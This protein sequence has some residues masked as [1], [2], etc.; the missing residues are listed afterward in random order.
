MRSIELVSALA[1]VA[2]M[3]GSTGVAAVDLPVPLRSALVV[4]DDRGQCPAA[5]FT[6]I[7]AAVDVATPGSVV[8]VCPGRYEESV[9]VGTSLRLVGVPGVYDT[10][11]CFAASLQALSPLDYPIVGPADDPLDRT[12]TAFALAADDVDLSGFVVVGV[13]RGV[14]T[15]DAYS[16]YRIHHNLFANNTLG[17]HLGSGAGQA[18][19]GPSRVD[20]NCLRQN[21][22]GFS[23]DDFE[24]RSVLVNA[25]IDHNASFGTSERAYEGL[26]VNDV[27]YDHNDSRQDDNTII[28]SGTR[29]TRFIEN[30]IDR[31]RLAMEIGTGAPNLDL[32]ISRNNFVHIRPSTPSTAIGFNT[33]LTLSPNSNVT[34]SENTIAGYG[35][36]IGIGGPPFIA[37]Y[38]LE[39]SEIVGNVITDV[40]QNAIRL[41][42]LNN[43]ILFADNILH[44]NTQ[45]GSTR[46]AARPRRRPECAPRTTR[47]SATRHSGTA[48]GTPR[49]SRER[50]A[51]C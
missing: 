22:W 24:T 26:N 4:D 19:P 44:D 10:V 29:D 42:P 9:T 25:R 27:T 14:R 6:S 7:Q 39:H 1:S 46:S 28:L 37:G 20:H 40:V 21:D 35:T 2:L 34:V 43:H 11:D 23:N 41:R 3:V 18:T 47:S 8:K 15:D 32:E 36:G 30:Q 51:R 16:G 13:L 49:T 31:V 5:D 48:S 33:T 50:P 12:S 38:S 45:R 17:V